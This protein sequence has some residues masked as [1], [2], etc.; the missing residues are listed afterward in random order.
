MQ[1]TR[2]FGWLIFWGVLVVSAVGLALLTAR[3]V[4]AQ[5]GSQASSC[6]NCHETQ[7]KDP[8]NSDGTGWHQS[9]AFGDF[10]YICHAGNNQAT[11]KEAAH[12][13]M[14]APLADI[15][16]ACGQCHPNDLQ[17]RAN[18]Y[19][20]KLGAPIAAP[21]TAAAGP[22]AT[23][24]PATV[25]STAA[26]NLEA[27]SAIALAPSNAPLTDYVVRYSEKVLDQRPT[28]WGNIILISL[29]ILLVLGGALFINH[30]ERWISISFTERKPLDQDLPADVAG[31]A[32]QVAGLRPD[33]R[34][35]LARLLQKPAATAELL[36]ALDRL[37]ADSPSGGDKQ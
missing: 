18:V 22:F 13:G 5:C 4:K 14:V 1:R 16:V 23:A 28:N 17:A 31:I 37:S 11:D 8:V 19:S 7:A 30:R 36:A 32:A 33:A 6:K 20:V 21:T 27:S 15:N 3:P 9:H 10:C 25:P 29:L 35:A 34:K 24:T 12:A 2:H 26:G